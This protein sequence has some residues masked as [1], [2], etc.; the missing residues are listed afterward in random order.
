MTDIHW[1]ECVRCNK[2]A[3]YLVD[4]ICKRCWLDFP[5]LSAQVSASNY[6]F[7]R[8]LKLAAPQINPANVPN[9]EKPEIPVS[10]IEVEETEKED[11]IKVSP[12]TYLGLGFIAALVIIITIILK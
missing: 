7:N 2:L 10:N 4:E 11:E 8:R 1:R 12:Y 9:K 5:M 6:N 3:E